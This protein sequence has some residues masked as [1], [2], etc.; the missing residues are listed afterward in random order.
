MQHNDAASGTITLAGGGDE[1]YRLPPGYRLVT[2]MNGQ[3]LFERIA[4][5]LVPRSLSPDE[6]IASVP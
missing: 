2:G 3:L 6:G 4:P 5:D 1:D